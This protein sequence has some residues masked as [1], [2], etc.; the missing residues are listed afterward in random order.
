ML[1]SECS[2][3]ARCRAV[4]LQFRIHHS[5]FRILFASLRSLRTPLLLSVAA[6][7]LVLPTLPLHEWSF[8]SEAVNVAT[9]L[10]IRRTGHWFKPTLQGQLRLNKPPLTAW[11]TAAAITDE[12]LRLLQSRDPSQR[13]RGQYRLAWQARYPT[14]L[15]LCISLIAIYELGLTIGGAEISVLST[16]VA[17]SML[18][19][20]R[21]ARWA[22]TDTQLAIW[23]SI[24]NAFLARAIFK[25]QPRSY[26][27]AGVA[28]GLAFLAKGPI[29]LIMTVLPMFVI[30]VLVRRQ[31][32][33]ANPPPP[34][35]GE[36][37]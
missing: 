6:F 29:A 8:G 32:I 7:L 12:T 22:Q 17:M 5:E 28:V 3:K 34:P 30:R 33:D 24:C 14:A 20:M 1:N 19:F 16:L 10:E 23:V 2:K 31:S 21:H 36:G 13:E 35:A 15:L 37:R 9:A 4:A 26:I 11:L 18:L 25:N 27:G